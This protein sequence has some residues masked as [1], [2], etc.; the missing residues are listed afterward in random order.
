MAILTALGTLVV[1]IV[2]TVLLI[3]SYIAGNVVVLPRIYTGVIIVLYCLIAYILARESSTR[4][5]ASIMLVVL[6]FCLASVTALLWSINTPISHLLFVF[7]I[8]IAAILLGKRALILA[9]TFSAVAVV[10]IQILFTTGVYI[11]DFSLLAAEST[12]LDAAAYATLFFVF[13]ILGWFT[14]QQIEQSLEKIQTSKQVVTNERN[15]LKELLQKER[16]RLEDAQRIEMA[17]LYR[18]TELGRKTSSVLHD[19]ANQLAVLSID[20]DTKSQNKSIVNARQS[21]KEIEELI[22]KVFR[23]ASHASETNFQL[24]PVMHQILLE[25]SEL[26]SKSNVELR[27][28]LDDSHI[29]GDKELLIIII[30]VLMSNALEAIQLSNTHQNKFIELKVRRKKDNV[31]IIVRDSAKSLSDVVIGKLFKETITTKASGHG[32]GLYMAQS[33]IHNHFK[34]TLTVKNKP[35]TTFTVSLP[36]IDR[37]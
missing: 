22:E 20:L 19:L 28:S 16:R 23:T 3:A 30:R 15:K 24:K 12:F 1:S 29:R 2:L 14:A 21:I 31:Q 27:A 34:G 18:F 13:A 8:L 6:Y 10:A 36:S 35:D 4:M 33:V 7:T 26:C 37:V 17:Q 5:Q 9:S 11:P 32:I 25:F